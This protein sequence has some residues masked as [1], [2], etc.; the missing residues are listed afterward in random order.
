MWLEITLCY[1]NKRRC[2]KRVQEV[3]PTLL[4]QAFTNSAPGAGLIRMRA[5]DPF[6]FEF[7]A[8]LC[9]AST[10]PIKT[11]VLKLFLAQTAVPL[12]YL[13]LNVSPCAYA[14]MWY[15]VGRSSSE[16]IYRAEGEHGKH[17][18]HFESLFAKNKAWGYNSS[19]HVPYDIHFHY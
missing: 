7:G 14:I 6:G 2:Y 3:F 15:D 8:Q 16:T 5:S 11:C 9:I 19:V 13:Y 4:L 18:S 12:A 1:A 10:A 17:K